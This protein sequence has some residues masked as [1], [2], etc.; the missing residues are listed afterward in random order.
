MARTEWSYGFLECSRRC[1]STAPHHASNWHD[2]LRSGPDLR[3]HVQ[4]W[5]GVRGSTTDCRGAGHQSPD[6]GRRVRTQHPG[7]AADAPFEQCLAWSQPLPESNDDYVVALHY[8]NA[9]AELHRG[10]CALSHLFSAQ[11]Y[12]PGRVWI[13][14]ALLLSLQAPRVWQSRHR[15]GHTDE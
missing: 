4:P 8:G 13:L 2:S 6:D 14:N 3:L 7:K 11:Q 12:L 5:R 15:T 9:G 1:V 10:G